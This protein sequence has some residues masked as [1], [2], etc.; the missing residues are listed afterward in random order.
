MVITVD[1]TVYDGLAVTGLK[2][3]FSVADGSNAG[4]AKNGN[5]IRDVVGSYY[6]YQ[7]NINKRMSNKEIYDRFYEVVSS[8]DDSHI[9]EL[10][11]GQGSYLF[12]GYVT[13]GTDDFISAANDT[14]DWDNLSFN[15]IAMKPKRRP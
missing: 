9:F 6:N 8:P 4:R 11:Y 13:S 2:R 5:M 7:I 12:E 10:P 1:G 15:I 3:T 14:N